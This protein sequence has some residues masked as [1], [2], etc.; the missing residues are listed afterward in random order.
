[1]S[2]IV[3]TDFPLFRL[4][5]IYL[6]YAEAVLRGG[7]GGDK[8]TALQ[9]INDLRKRSY[10]NDNA[11]TIKAN[12]LTLDFLLDERSRELFYEAQRRTDLIRFNKFTSSSYLWPWKGNVADGVA[13]SDHFKVYPL[14]ADDTG[15]NNNLV[16]NSGY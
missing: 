2:N 14:P 13:V 9:L 5:E 15:A 1:P 3:Y 10:N 11:A 8:A 6:N 16:Q 7:S 12:E 4:G